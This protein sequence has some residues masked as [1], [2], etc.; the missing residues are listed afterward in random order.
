MRKK[1][2]LITQQELDS[3]LVNLFLLQKNKKIDGIPKV[4][5]LGGS[6]MVVSISRKN[7]F[8]VNISI[9]SKWF[10]L[11]LY[12]SE[13][14]ETNPRIK[15]DFP[16]TAYVTFQDLKTIYEEVQK[17]KVEYGLLSTVLVAQYYDQL[18]KN[19]TLTLDYI[20]EIFSSCTMQ[21]WKQ[22]P[23]TL[24]NKL[25]N[26][27]KEEKP[28][29]PPK[30]AKFIEVKEDK[31]V[32]LTEQELNQQI[33]L[34]PEKRSKKEIE[35]ELEDLDIQMRLLSLE[36]QQIMLQQRINKLKRA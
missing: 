29:I 14:L 36:K 32:K 17:L 34:E 27:P 13:E 18:P 15:L 28:Q 5:F 1:D 30:K 21:T 10:R 20:K 35:E 19:F 3:R 25:I 12:T 6:N 23:K 11:G 16:Q 8:P 31:E 4:S 9:G 7:C 2:P 24:L 26:I 33:N 22:K